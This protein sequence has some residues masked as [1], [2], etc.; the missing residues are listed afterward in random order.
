M[1]TFCKVTELN[2]A[3][4]SQFMHFVVCPVDG[5]ARSGMIF[6]AHSQSLIVL[7]H[8]LVWTLSWF[9]FLNNSVFLNTLTTYIC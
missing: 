9:C 5:S 6:T 8:D 3:L 1:V 2:S 4:G 7:P